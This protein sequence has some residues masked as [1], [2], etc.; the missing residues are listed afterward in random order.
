MKSSIRCIQANLQHAKAAT[1]VLSRRFKEEQLDIAFIQEPW[2]SNTDRVNGLGNISEAGQRPAVTYR[3]VRGTDWG[4]YKISLQSELRTS[5]TTIKNRD[6]IDIANGQICSAII[7]A[8]HEN[9]PLKT[10]Q[11][12]RG[13]SWWNKKLDKKRKE[14]RRLFNRAKNS[15]NWDQYRSALTDYNKEIRRAKRESWRRFCESIKDV[16]RSTRIHKI[17]SRSPVG[18]CGSIKR[19]D[20]SYTDSGME[21]LQLLALNHFPGSLSLDDEQG[22]TPVAHD[23]YPGCR[24]ALRRAFQLRGVPDAAIPTLRASLSKNTQKQYNSTFVK[25]WKWCNDRKTSQL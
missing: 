21:T 8:Y 23:P 15:G 9:T 5:L 18:E 25:W 14:V 3:D 12:N 17:L 4:G 1:Y 20:G 19:P 13:A 2:T 7:S 10:K 11:D 24:E 6:E 22:T 16:P